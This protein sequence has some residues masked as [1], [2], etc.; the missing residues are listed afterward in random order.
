MNENNNNLLDDELL[1]TSF[2]KLDLEIY[3]MI[4]NIEVKVNDIV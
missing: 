3:F 4:K 2:D 1:E